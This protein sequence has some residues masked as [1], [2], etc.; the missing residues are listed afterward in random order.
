MTRCA[1][2]VSGQSHLLVQQSSLPGQAGAGILQIASLL[3]HTMRAGAGPCQE[4]LDQW[5][6]AVKPGEGRLANCLAGELSVEGQAEH[7]G[8][9][10]SDACKKDLTT[11]KLQRS[12]NINMDIPLAKAC[13]VDAEKHCANKYEVGV[14]PAQPPTS[15]RQPVLSL[16][17]MR[18]SCCKDSLQQ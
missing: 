18:S 3:R 6:A 7:K 17:S 11:F 13:K 10:M 15:E 8:A 1:Y 2:R 14:L 12:T 5:C 9:K 4:E 16:V